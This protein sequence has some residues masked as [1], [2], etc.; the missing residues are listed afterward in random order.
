VI[1]SFT[2]LIMQINDYLKVIL[3]LVLAVLYVRAMALSKRT[4]WGIF[5]KGKGV[6][7]S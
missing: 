7:I 4:G 6:I 2:Q 5:R 1:L 3:Q